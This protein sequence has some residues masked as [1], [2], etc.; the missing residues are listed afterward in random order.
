MLP[1][2]PRSRRHASIASVHPSMDRRIAGFVAMAS[3]SQR[4]MP[5]SS[6]PPVT[7]S[8]S[9]ANDASTASTEPS[10]GT[11]YASA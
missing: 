6:S 8:A 9:S 10:S 2:A 11:S 1:D 3:P 7:N 4:G 5:A